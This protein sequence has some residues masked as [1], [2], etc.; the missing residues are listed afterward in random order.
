MNTVAL[1]LGWFVILASTGF[2]VTWLALIALD[3]VMH[4]LRIFWRFIEYVANRDQYNQW[5]VA[6]RNQVRWPAE[7]IEREGDSS[8][9]SSNH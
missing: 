5:R 9:S 7:S 2:V 6:H 4:R 8:D 1:Y 3:A